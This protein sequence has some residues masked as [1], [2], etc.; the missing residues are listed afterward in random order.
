MTYFWNFETKIEWWWWLI[1][2]IVKKLQGGYSNGGGDD[3]GERV[4]IESNMLGYDV[5][6]DLQH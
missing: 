3:D 1:P 2:S 4:W 6:S 5:T